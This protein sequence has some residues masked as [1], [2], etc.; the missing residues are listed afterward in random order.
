MCWADGG[1][2]RLYPWFLED[3]NMSVVVL[4]L[5]IISLV[6]AAV[7]MV[8]MLVKDKPFYGGIGLCVLLGPG[9]VLTFWY[10]TL[11]WG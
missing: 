3:R 1:V 4:A 10:T 7:L 6:A 9:A 8:A 11:S 2:I 5:L